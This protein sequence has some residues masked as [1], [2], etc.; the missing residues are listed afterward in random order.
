M[1]FRSRLRSFLRK[2]H[3]KPPN[4][5]H[6]QCYLE[7]SNFDEDV[8]LKIKNSP[9]VSKGVTIN[10]LHRRSGGLHAVTSGVAVH[11]SQKCTN[12]PQASTDTTVHILP[13]GAQPTLDTGDGEVN[14]SRNINIPQASTNVAV[15]IS[16]R[17]AQPTLDTDNGGAI[18]SRNSSDTLS[19]FSD[20]IL[21]D[22]QRW[23]DP[24]SV[25]SD[26]AAASSQLLQQNGFREIE[27]ESEWT[28][29]VFWAAL[30]EHDHVIRYLLAVPNPQFMNYNTALHAA[31]CNGLLA[32][33]QTVLDQ[34]ARINSKNKDGETA[35]HKA[36][37]TGQIK[38]IKLLLA[39]GADVRARDRYGFDPLDIS[40]G[41][42]E[43]YKILLQHKNPKKPLPVETGK[44]YKA[45]KT[46]RAMLTM[47]LSC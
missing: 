39:R 12:I 42:A 18:D 5:N 32:I 11:P 15:Y 8:L 26:I 27:S 23:A 17:G 6:N 9:S 33:V 46:R 14:G 20:V 3:A 4:R 1:G 37:R 13:K 45:V 29:A 36:A 10:T 25:S 28:K 47:C 21:H 40:I 22:P 30:N 35:L 2:T 31:A 19:I 44:L 43:A 38:V 16:P 7:N 24:L 41:N 34:G